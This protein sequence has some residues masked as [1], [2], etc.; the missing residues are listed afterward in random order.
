M[1]SGYS[2]L[3]LL[4]SGF[5]QTLC[6]CEYKILHKGRT[7]FLSDLSRICGFRRLPGLLELSEIDETT[8][9]TASLAG[10]LLRSGNVSLILSTFYRKPPLERSRLATTVGVSWISPPT[11]WEMLG[12]KERDKVDK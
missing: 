3:E 4:R 8:G 2:E 6:H 11:V 7:G 12:I 10:V 1:L 5:S 9:P